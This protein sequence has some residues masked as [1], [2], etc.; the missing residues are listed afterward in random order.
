MGWSY[1]TYCIKNKTISHHPLLLSFLGTSFISQTFFIFTVQLKQWVLAHVTSVIHNL[2]FWHKS[3]YNS[4]L[5]VWLQS[6]LFLSLYQYISMTHL[7]MHLLQKKF[8]IR[9]L[10]TKL[11]HVLEVNYDCILA[12]AFM[13]FASHKYSDSVQCSQNWKVWQVTGD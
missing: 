7:L 8:W 10:T 13:H 1:A 11:V 3:K 5:Q 2:F 6:L 9:C 12:I 4:A